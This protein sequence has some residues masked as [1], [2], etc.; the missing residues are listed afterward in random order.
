MRFQGLAV[1]LAKQKWPEFIACERKNDL[2]LDAHA[3]ASL[4]PDWKG[5]GKGLVCSITA[6]Y[7]K[8]ATDAAR[9]KEHFKDVTILVFATPRKVTNQTKH[10]WATCLRKE[11]EYE[12]EIISREDIIASLMMPKNAALGPSHLRVPVEVDEP[13]LELIARIRQ[14][15]GEVTERWNARTKGHPLIDL[16]AERQRGSE[17]A[18]VCLNNIDAALREG[19]RVLLEAPAGRGKTTALIQ[20]AH[21]QLPTAG[22]AFLIDLPSWISSRSGI[23]E[24]ISGA[25]SFQARS[26]DAA[27]LAK[28]SNAEHFLFLL[29]GWNEIAESNSIQAVE[30]LR[31]LE[32]EFPRAGIIVATRTHHIVPPLPGAM[33]LRLLPLTAVAPWQ[34]CWRADST[35]SGTSSSPFY[36]IKTNRSGSR[37]IG[38]G[39]ISVYRVWDPSGIGSYR[40]GAKTHGAI[41]FLNSCTVGQSRRSCRMRWPIR[42]RK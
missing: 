38:S 25:P 17:S 28:A 31:E 33:K 15:A 4:A 41:S 5:K 12:L 13:D 19:R 16:R 30:A 24:Y 7:D 20:L 8:L 3:P 23:L 9:A 14:A 37:H 27:A 21:H 26:I 2:G 29:N 22:T 35:T 36:R 40:H 6:T 42:A 1:V 34:G 32:R 11:F 10:K 18:E 39:P